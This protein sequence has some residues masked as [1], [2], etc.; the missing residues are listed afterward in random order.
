MPSDKGLSHWKVRDL[1]ALGK[2]VATCNS[3]KGKK[4]RS[5]GFRVSFLKVNYR[6]LASQIRMKSMWSHSTGML[7]SIICF[8]YKIPIYCH[9]PKLTNLMN[10]TQSKIDPFLI[11]ILMDFFVGLNCPFLVHFVAGSHFLKSDKWTNDAP[12]P[13]L[14]LNRPKRLIG[15]NFFIKPRTKKINFFWLLYQF[16]PHQSFRMGSKTSSF[17]SISSGIGNP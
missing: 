6:G 3:G 11:D 8:P 4:Y 14:P 7:F 5:I 2:E 15:P 12:N 13:E 1:L 17:P 9:K 10:Y 16:Y